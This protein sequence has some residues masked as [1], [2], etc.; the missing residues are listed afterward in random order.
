M[1]GYNCKFSFTTSIQTVYIDLKNKDF[2]AS[3]SPGAVEYAYRKSASTGI[4]WHIV[5]SDPLSVSIPESN[6]V[7]LQAYLVERRMGNKIKTKEI[8][9][10]I[11]RMII[12]QLK[13]K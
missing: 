6:S 11:L 3:L 1:T 4:F 7:P 13:Q 9:A 8:K 5:S 10:A 2:F 12:S